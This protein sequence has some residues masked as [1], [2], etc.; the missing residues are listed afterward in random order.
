MSSKS[1]SA[2]SYLPGSLPKKIKDFIEASS[3]TDAYRQRSHSHHSLVN[4]YMVATFLEE[5]NQYV[6]PLK[7]DAGLRDLAQRLHLW[8][9]D[10][11]TQLQRDALQAIGLLE[12]YVEQ[13]L[14]E[15]LKFVER[16]IIVDSAQSKR[17]LKEL[18][19]MKKAALADLHQL[20]DE[21]KKQVSQ[22]HMDFA[23]TDLEIH[24]LSPFIPGFT[25]ARAKGLKSLSRQSV[26]SSSKSVADLSASFNLPVQSGLSP[27]RTEALAAIEKFRDMVNSVAE[28]FTNVI[29]NGS[30]KILEERVEKMADVQDSF[31]TMGTKLYRLLNSGGQRD[32]EGDVDSAKVE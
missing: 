20:K 27:E 4:T 31:E 18:A 12:K 13:I 26:T 30:M 17:R 29:G 22:H 24:D 28:D 25:S 7:R 21:L 15:E 23:S 5:A 1:K 3:D 32:Y 16:T 11:A 8:P 2:Q 10:M 14:T 9:G 19:E 6:P